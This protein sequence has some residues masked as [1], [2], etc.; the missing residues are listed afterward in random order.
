MHL[1]RRLGLV[2]V[3]CIASGAMI[4]S[5]IFVL[6]GMAFAQA[7][8]SVVLSYTL[9][10]MLAATG[11][12]STAELST[13]MPRAGSDYF[14]IT[15]SVGPAF[16]TVAGVLNWVS[17]SLKSSFALVGMA[18]L[19]KVLAGVDMRVSGVLLGMVF[20]GINLAGVMEAARLQVALVMLLLGLMT[21][22]VFRGLPSVSAARFENFAPGGLRAL[23]STAGMVFVAFGG[24]LKAA[25]MAEE[26][27]NPGVTLPRGMILSLSL[28]GVFYVLM[29][30]VTVGIS[31]PS[32]LASTLT[33][34]SDGA[35]LLM[36]STG[37]FLIGLAASLA[38]LTT[39]NA[40]IMAGSRYLVALG[41]DGIVP[42]RL[43]RVGT[44]SG[45]P[46]AAIL[47]TGALVILPQFLNLRILVESASLGLILTNMLALVSV[48]VLRESRIQNYRPTFRA[49][50]YPWLQLAGLFG[51]CFIIVQM[52]EEA[53]LISTGLA[54]SGFLIYWFYGRSRAMHE[55]ALLQLVSRLTSGNRISGA[56]ESELRE[57]IRERDGIETDRFDSMIESCPVFDLL[58]PISMEDLF[59][60]AAEVIGQRMNTD[61]GAVKSLL[62][63]QEEQSSTAISSYLAI[64]HLALEGSSRFDIVLVRCLG[65]IRF[66]DE[67]PSVKAVVFLAGSLKERNLHL[68]S[69]AAIAQTV[70]QD[71]F[72]RMW[73]SARGEQALRDI[74][75]LS[76]RKRES[77][78]TH[79][80]G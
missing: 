49:P 59:E 55:S 64:P 8:P 58:G 33:P 1:K 46:H 16:G 77:R 9:A 19:L 54:V 45:T 60:L 37:V 24:L 75:L 38:F 30:G 3:F 57:I 23:F 74:F 76:G 2:D 17:F 28:I 53:F 50:L 18:A 13:A 6:P 25:S 71:D 26:V 39:A 5:G 7:G 61:P 20:V 40:G 51:F 36:G 12:L 67:A 32:A 42:E 68:R 21:L 72:E 10:A 34:I 29:V 69:L 62:I 47:L 27:R 31:E 22:Y 11:L 65:G 80:E 79:Q 44:G 63:Q 35:G 4:S 56:I 52:Q 43:G 15:R 41:R 48:I 78:L 14:F 73:R 66:N 70:A